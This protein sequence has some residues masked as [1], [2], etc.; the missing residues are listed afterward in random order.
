MHQLPEIPASKEEKRDF[1]NRQLD[2][3]KQILDDLEKTVKDLRLKKD[4]QRILE[5]TIIKQLEEAVE[6]RSISPYRASMALSRI[7]DSSFKTER[8]L[9]EALDRVS[10]LTGG[11]TPEDEINPTANDTQTYTKDVQKAAE[12]AILDL[13]AYAES[14]KQSNQDETETRQAQ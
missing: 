6:D 9:M 12:K 11:F 14:K 1:L 10:G 4:K 13:V 2:I 7:A 5:A 8:S 3:H